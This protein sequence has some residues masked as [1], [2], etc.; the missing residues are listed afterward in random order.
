MKSAV[1]I[2][3]AVLFGMTAAAW[4]ETEE[5]FGRVLDGVSGQPLAG[6]RVWTEGDRTVSFE[7]GSFALTS[8]TGTLVVRKPGYQPIKIAG[9]HVLRVEL[10]PVAPKALYM[11]YWAADSRDLRAHLLQLLQETGMNALVIDIKSTRGDVAFRSSL[12]LAR[13]IGAQRA[14]TLKDLP[15]FLADLKAHGIYTIARLAVFKDDKLAKRR[16]DLAVYDPAGEIWE[17]RESISWSDPFI[18]QVRDY[19]LDLAEEVASLGFDEIQFDYIRFPARSD[20][21][22]AR[23]NT[24]DNRVAAINQFLA[25]AKER[26][27]PYPVMTAANIFGYICW[28]PKDQKIGQRLVDMGEQVDY[29]SPMLYPS[30]FPY[31]IPGYP[32]PVTHNFEVIAHSLK[33]AVSLSGLEPARFRPW[34]QAFRDYAFDRRSYRADDIHAQINASDQVGSSGWML[35]NAASRFSLAGLQQALSYGELNLVDVSPKAGDEAVL[36]H[37]DKPVPGPPA[38]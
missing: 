35:W 21:K 2:L 4:A 5:V 3:M 12:P 9:D 25:Q 16:P 32:V 18:Q 27:A 23:A 28:K 24:G 13:Q 11:S 6:A 15:D 36:T 1:T 20:L 22:F 19:N 29:L 14:R 31:G 7:D 17:D 26:L 10:Q 34:L 37:S 30:G 38:L 8:E 33:K